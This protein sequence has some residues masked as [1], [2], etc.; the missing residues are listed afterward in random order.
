[1]WSL[2]INILLTG[3]VSLI[4]NHTTNLKIKEKQAPL[5]EVD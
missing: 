2:T 1:M 3:N 4:V 5:S